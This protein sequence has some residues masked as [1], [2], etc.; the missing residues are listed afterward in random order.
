MNDTTHNNG[1]EIFAIEAIDPKMVPRISSSPIFNQGMSGSNNLSSLG[2]GRAS[3]PYIKGETNK[4]QYNQ[5]LGQTN[6]QSNSASNHNKIPDA[7][8]SVDENFSIVTFPN[9]NSQRTNFNPRI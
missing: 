3:S 2:Q 7:Y 6:K 4:S 8:A 5:T 1:K 9:K